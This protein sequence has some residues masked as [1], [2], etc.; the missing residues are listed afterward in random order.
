MSRIEWYLVDIEIAYL[1]TI[2][3]IVNNSMIISFRI[4]IGE[5]VGIDG[6]AD[7]HFGPCIRIVE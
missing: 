5:V 4:Q 2:T 7:R 1:T 6:L 3:R